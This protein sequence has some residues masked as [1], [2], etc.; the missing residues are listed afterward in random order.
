MP[1]PKSPQVTILEGRWFPRKNVSLRDLFLPLFTVWTPDGDGAHHYEMFTNAASF[2][3]AIKHAFSGGRPQTIYIAAHGST[4][5]IQGFHDEGISR[6]MIRNAFRKAKN[7]QRRRGVYFGSCLF[8]TRRNAEFILRECPRVAWIVGYTSS[9]DWI[10]SSVI[11]LFFLRHYLFP[12]PGRGRARPITHAAR[13]KYAV[14]QVR[15]K[16]HELAFSTGFHAYVRVR[17][18]GGGIRDIFLEGSA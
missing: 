13:L 11:D 17:G 12:E 7:S 10:D 3:D 8:G 14:A 1:R 4:T 6:A 16:M 2:I 9:V 15:D 5:G 18:P